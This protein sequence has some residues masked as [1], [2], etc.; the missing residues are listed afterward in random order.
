LQQPL[1]L[2]LRRLIQASH[3]PT[4]QRLRLPVLRWL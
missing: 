4:A 3:L 1:Q 2:F